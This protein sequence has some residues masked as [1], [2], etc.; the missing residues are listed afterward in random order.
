M[1]SKRIAGVL[2]AAVVAGTLMSQS[3]WAAGDV[4]AGAAKA[5]QCW[6]C[7]GITGWRNAYPGYSVPKL[8][9]QHPAYIVRAL[10]DYKSQN[11]AH[12]TMHAIAASLSDQDMEDIAAF[13][14]AVA[15]SN[16][17]KQ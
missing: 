6:G 11:R 12:P 10:K 8:G 16:A 2:A 3:A 1:K 5:G 17:K 13:V 4:K 14:T 15:Q 9:G 7:H